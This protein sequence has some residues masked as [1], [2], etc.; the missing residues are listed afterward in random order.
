MTQLHI[1]EAVV[2]Q[3]GLSNK[4]CQNLSLSSEQDL[5]GVLFSYP[6]LIDGTK[7]ILSE[8]F[9]NEFVRFKDLV[10]GSF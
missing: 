2:K 1:L 10:K 7:C 9:R 5:L 4:N 6:S 8:R 3:W